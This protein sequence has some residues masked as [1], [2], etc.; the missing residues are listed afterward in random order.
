[1]LNPGRRRPHSWIRHQAL[2][3]VRAVVVVLAMVV[4][5]VREGDRVVVLVVVL[6][7]VLVRV[8]VSAM[9]PMRL[10]RTRHTTRANCRT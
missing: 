6:V 10:R 5:V 2:Q 8:L 3:L 1:M 4:V 7:R 9:V